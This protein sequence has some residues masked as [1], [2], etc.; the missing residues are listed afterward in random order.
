L[1]EKEASVVASTLERD[2]E[3]LHKALACDGDTIKVSLS[4]ETLELV[5]MFIDAQAHGNCVLV[6]GEGEEVGPAEAATMLGM[7][8]PQVRKLMDKSLLQHRK[9]GAHHR[10]TV[11]S[12]QRFK[13]SERA[14]SRG[15][16]A[17]L[18][19]LQNELGLTE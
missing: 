18:A 15:A 3:V 7:S 19:D 13:E 9:V 16:M 4:R 10:I 11:A 6:V 1:N 12:I 14:R 5:A 17:D 8:R 2:S